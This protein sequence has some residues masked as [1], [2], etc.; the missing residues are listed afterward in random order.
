MTEL[1]KLK[2]ADTLIHEMSEGRLQ[3]AISIGNHFYVRPKDDAYIGMATRSDGNNLLTLINRY[4]DKHRED[5]RDIS[6]KA[7]AEKYAIQ[8]K[9]RYRE[10]GGN[11]SLLYFLK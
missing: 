8:T 4:M 7:K 6:A 9:Q 1:E 11:S 10:N 5:P 2:R 3:L